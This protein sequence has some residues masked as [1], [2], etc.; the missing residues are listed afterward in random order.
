MNTNIDNMMATIKL[1]DNSFKEKETGLS[2]LFG[3]HKY[4]QSEVREIWFN[5]IRVGI[6]HGLNN[7]SLQGQKI[8]ITRN[9]SNPRHK[10][11]YD[12]FLEL[13]S[14]YNCQIQYH[15]LHGMVVVDLLN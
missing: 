2:L 13:A 6:E 10:E 9:M 7:A 4:T 11:F 12:K 14:K 15:P 3:G 1:E 5:G 8:E